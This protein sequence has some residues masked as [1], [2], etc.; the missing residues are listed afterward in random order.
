[1]NTERKDRKTVAALA[2]LAALVLVGLFLLLFSSPEEGEKAGKEQAPPAGEAAAQAGGAAVSIGE[3]ARKAAG[4]VTEA[5]RPI[6]HE[7]Q[8]EAYG[9][10][11][12]PD[13]LIEARRAYISAKAALV[14]AEAALAASK[15]EYARLKELNQKNKNVS[16]RAL[17]RAE[18]LLKTDGAASLQAQEDMQS[19][20]DAR[21]LRWGGTL[22]GWITG[23]SSGYRRLVSVKDVLVRV[24]LPPGISVR[25]APE[26]TGIEAPGG[27]PVPAR[28]IMRAPGTDP[29]IQGMS[30]LY[31]APSSETRLIPGMNVTAYLPSGRMEKGFVIP[32]SAVVWLRGRAWAYVQRTEEGLFDRVEVPTSQP[33]REGYFVTDGVFRPGMRVVVRGAQALLSKE[34]LPP[35]G[36]GGEEE[37]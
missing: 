3:E 2:V 5:L 17:Q 4:I 20:R 36:G 19:A 25:S 37:D 16:D 18:A 8:I 33:V 29:R 27:P 28:L 14:E 11:L 24:T 6:R 31:L 7:E 15:K 30:F 34:S 22:S 32:L 35:P 10:V 12:Q 13:G 26:K 1:M 9:M 23:Y 21:E